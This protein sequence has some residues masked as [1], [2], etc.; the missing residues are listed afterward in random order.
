MTRSNFER[1]RINPRVKL[2][3]LHGIYVLTD[4]IVVV[5]CFQACSF[6]GCLALRDRCRFLIQHCSDLLDHVVRE[7]V[8]LRET[9]NSPR[10]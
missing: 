7:A 8:Q 9:R 6:R 2:S 4:E 5:A 1:S 10:I 3:D